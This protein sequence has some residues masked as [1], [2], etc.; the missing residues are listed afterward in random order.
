MLSM[1]LFTCAERCKVPTSL[2]KTEGAVRAA[3]NTGGV[4]VILTVI[5]PEANGTDLVSPAL[6]ERE[7][8]T[9]RASELD[10]GFGPA[11]DRVGGQLPAVVLKPL[12]TVG[13]FLWR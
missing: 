1:P 9:A 11:H 13:Q 2:L 10:A 12:L 3:A 6:I 8:P 7:A 5:L 4:L